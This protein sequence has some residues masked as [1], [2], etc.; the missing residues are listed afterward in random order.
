MT[1]H[2]HFW[3]YVAL[4]SVCLFWGTTYL[5]IRMALESFSPA[6]LI[7]TR[8]VL[9]GG[10]LLIAA[11]AMKARIPRGREFWL[12][13]LYGTI[14]IGLGN[15]ALAFAETWIPSGL[16]ALFIT[17]SPFWM[18][19]TEA[20]LPGGARLHAPTIAGM[21]VGLSGTA[22]LVSQSG[23][24]AFGGGSTVSAF[25]L[26]Q[27][28]CAGWAFGS[29]SHRRLKATAHPVV[30]GAIQ[31]LAAGIGFL[32]VSP[33]IEHPAAH[34]TVHG[35]LALAWLITFG[36]IVGYS[37]YAYALNH[38][39]VSVVSIYTYINPV[40]AVFLGWLFYR[41]PFGGREALAMVIVFAG[42]AIVKKFGSHPP[43]PAI[44]DEI[45]QHST[46]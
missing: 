8:Y 3:A 38:L 37:S 18:V 14:I 2:A 32:V 1:R 10:I 34:Y 35:F 43:P 4:S 7:G 17:T 12:T 5:G 15:G 30:S 40:V 46:A 16:A 39:P 36:S 26:L 22:L 29:I 45:E 27:L 13:A 31:Q 20:L 42:V 21:L 25:L 41:E 28:G 9:S 24:H 44:P 19:G 33:V 11:V 23:A 6:L